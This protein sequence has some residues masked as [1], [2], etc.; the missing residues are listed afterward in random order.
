[1]TALQLAEMLA[2]RPSSR[3]RWLARCPAH[4]DRRPSLSITQGERG[5]LLRCW[6]GCRTEDVLAA[7]HLPMSA[8]F[9]GAKLSPSARTEAARIRQIRDAAAKAEH[10][11]ECEHNRKLLRL[12]HL[13]DALGAKLA[14][15]PDDV[16]LGRLFHRACDWLHEAETITKD[17][18]L[19]EN[20]PPERIA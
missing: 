14:R 6:A 12:E 19:A 5:A 4:D 18:R 2:A 11:A 17:K 16:E 8:L 13:R 1:M 9:N 15:S 10:H 20:E 7:I 3:G